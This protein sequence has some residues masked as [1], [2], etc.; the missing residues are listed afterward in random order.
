[1]S[2]ITREGDMLAGTGH[3]AA[4]RDNRE[5]NALIASDRV[6]GTDVFDHGGE[7]IGTVKRFHVN[8]R[9]GKAEYA[10]MEFGGFLGI[11][12]DTHHLPWDVLDY[13][14]HRGGYVVDLTRE[15]LDAAPRNDAATSREIDHAYGTDIRQYYGLPPLP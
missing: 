12:K 5:P 10:E 11:G 3:D 4:A 15:Q 1:M 7:R 6:E 8:K 2:E 9:T 14:V 13:D